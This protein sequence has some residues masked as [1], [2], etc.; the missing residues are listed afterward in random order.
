MPDGST[1]V[2][3]RC[4]H[5]YPTGPR[6]IVVLINATGEELERARRQGWRCHKMHG[7]KAYLLCL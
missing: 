7:R 6:S 1:C 4:E 2:P 5:D 3:W